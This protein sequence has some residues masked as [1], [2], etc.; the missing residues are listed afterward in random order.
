M[1][2]SITESWRIGIAQR[3]KSKKSKWVGTWFNTIG[4]I[5]KFRHAPCLHDHVSG[6]VVWRMIT[7]LITWHVDITSFR[8]RTAEQLT[9]ET[10]TVRPD[11]NLWPSL[12]GQSIDCAIT[13]YKYPAHFIFREPLSTVNWPTSPRRNSLP[14]PSHHSSKAESL[15]WKHSRTISK[16]VLANF[17][18]HLGENI[19][20]IFRLQNSLGRKSSLSWI[21]S[22]TFSPAK[23]S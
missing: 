16:L 18:H 20:R 6:H 1:I 9:W 5:F 2:S 17:P 12:I 8:K 23:F 11:E 7:W 14:L 10:P 3:K 19:Q 15:L 13:G 4:L 21:Y 22:K